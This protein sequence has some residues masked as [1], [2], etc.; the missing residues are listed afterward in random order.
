MA[1]GARP[2]AAGRAAAGSRTA[3]RAG[4]IWSLVALVTWVLG[5]PA[6]WDVPAKTV[7][8]LRDTL[9]VYQTAA[10]DG[11]FFMGRAGVAPGAAFYPAVALWRTL[12]LTL[13]IVVAVAL[14]ALV[15][16]AR[17]R[18]VTP[19]PR[20]VDLLAWLGFALA[21]G[22]ALSL[23][24]SKYER[25]LLPALAALALAAGLA[26][27]AWLR[28]WAGR[29]G[30]G[31][32]RARLAALAF[33]LL[34]LEPLAGRGWRDGLAFYNPLAGGASAARA[35]LPQGWGEGTEQV[36]AYLAS[37][38]EAEGLTV[39][40]EG[41]VSLLPDFPGRIIPARGA[42]CREADFVLVYVFDRQLG[43]PA[44]RAY[45]GQEPVFVARVRG[46]DYAWLYA[47]GRDCPP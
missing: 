41:S 4:A 29:P 14:A 32:D 45:E 13:P 28:A 27:G 35:V 43:Q 44:A 15:G 16:A 1:R 23:A 10:Y 40:A 25:Y 34:L 30:A 33:V 42:A 20:L 12:P 8:Q 39:A 37:R 5:W 11:M 47:G 22:A 21:Y 31:P 38:G 2:F 36:A 26:A 17:R 9:A 19:V 18:P 6:M 7:G 3:L 46:A 24:D